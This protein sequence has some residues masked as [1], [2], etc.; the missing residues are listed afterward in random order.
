MSLSS[1][2]HP[3]TNGQ[4]ERKIQ[5]LGL[6]L[7]AYCQEDQFSWSHF[8]PWAEYA[9]EGCEAG[10]VL[11]QGVLCIPGYQTPPFPWTGGPSEVPAVDYWF[12]A[13]ERVWDSTHII[14][15]RA[16]RSAETQDL[17]R[18]S[19]RPNSPLSTWRPGVVVHPRP[20]TPPAL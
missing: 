18:R 1:D 6:C 19:A 11:M 2:Y 16:V 4:A 20:A 17:H 13:S 15:Q 7:R 9:L 14:L 12:R 3:Q 8:L 5:E 10:G